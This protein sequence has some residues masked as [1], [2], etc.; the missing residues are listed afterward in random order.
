[1][2][3]SEY[4]RPVLLRKVLDLL[5]I[6][7]GRIYLDATVGGGGYTRE[8][9]KKGGFVLAL[10][11]DINA[12][13]FLR[14]DAD[15]AGFLARGELILE[16]E[17]FIRVEEIAD[18]HGIQK[19]QGAVFDL[20]LS[21]YQLDKSGRG[22]SFRKNEPLDMRFDTGGRVKA[23]D[24][25]NTYSEKELYEIFTKYAEELHSRS[26]AVAVL[27]ARSLKGNITTTGQLNEII[28]SAV[29]VTNKK[30]P[31]K[32]LRMIYQALRIA[33]N[34][35]LEN[36]LE[37]LENSIHRLGT[38]GRIAVLSYHSLEDRIVKRLF[39]DYRK[40]A[41]LRIITGRPERP[42]WNE[43]KENRRAKSAKLRVGEMITNGL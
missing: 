38:K 18:K 28:R 43:I 6:E 22:F 14:K 2:I 41:V 17:N 23:S 24:I 25:L 20:G 15:L 9:L 7:K 3:V 32:S 37:G 12:V 16:N 31:D 40:K 36:L 21:S 42:E 11:A 39:D 10:D 19:F 29:P 4:H 13:E 26:V 33:V 35:E 27:R 34:R 1:M 5:K 8:I 30:Q